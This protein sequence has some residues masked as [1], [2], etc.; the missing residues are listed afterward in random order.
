[1]KK[2]V[3]ITAI[4]VLF[5]A[6][7]FAQDIKTNHKQKRTVNG[8]VYT[9]E[10]KPLAGATV[11]V[12]GTSIGA[13]TNSKGAF[14]LSFNIDKNE[15]P[16]VISYVGYKT[17]D[18]KL[19]PKEDNLKIVL[20]ES[21]YYLEQIV[22]TG[23]RAEQPLKEAAII[24]RM[25]SEKEISQ[26]NPMDVTSIL[27]FELPGLQFGRQHGTGLPTMNF[28]GGDG[29][30]VLFL[31]DGEK[32]SGEGAG[33]NVDFS[34]FNVDRIER[35][36]VV[37]GAM[38]TLYG[39]S[40]LGGVINII[41]KDANRPFTADFDSRYAS[42]GEHKYSL[43]AGT[44]L[45][46]FSSLS[47]FS[48][49]KKDPF[50]AYD[51]SPAYH[52]T[53]KPDG[54][55]DTQ[56]YMPSVLEVTG[57][58]LWDFN[59]KLKYNISERLTAQANVSYYHNKRLA[60]H[61]SENN[62]DLYKDLAANIKLRYTLSEGHLLNLSYNFDDFRKNIVSLK[63]DNVNEIYSDLNNVVNLNYVGDL[64]ENN[65]LSAGFEFASE[66]L[67]H[68]MFADS[69]FRSTTNYVFF[70]Q[71]EGKYWDKVSL[72]PG[73]RF[74]YHSVY[75]LNVTPRLS[76]MYSLNDFVFRGGIA[77]GYRSPSLKELYSDYNM[78]GLNLFNIVGNPDLKPEKSLQYSASTE[79]SRSNMNASISANY[80]TYTDRIGL[81]WQDNAQNKKD[82]VY[83]N[84]NNSATVGLDFI[85][86]WRY[87]FGL[88]LNFSYSYIQETERV[89]GL[90]YF[91][92][93]PHSMNLGLRYG[94]D[95]G[96]V[97]SF[98]SFNSMWSSGIRAVVI[99]TT[100]GVSYADYEPRY[101]STLQFGAKLPYGLRANFGIDNIFDFRDSNVSNT[102]AILP[103]QGRSYVFSLSMNIADL[104]N[105]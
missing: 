81:R 73:V 26:I 74:D 31:V 44:K 56:V 49:R 10:G 23:T 86:R 14:K 70:I 2:I 1:M 94:F 50:L 75:N 87:D 92:M 89:N 3:L 16:L 105:L 65:V 61:K 101:R 39:S 40:A 67:K 68:Y 95:I 64:G 48:F 30:Y 59:Q 34:R 12:K 17:V 99:E 37:K 33:N 46:D 104:L 38:S 7:A 100:E 41:T 20:E 88:S 83:Y 28:Q 18:Y 55:I 29:S 93:R 19:K 97:E 76:A 79:F 21:P 77:A 71:N 9:A 5:S 80:N 15:V 84:T 27:Q 25:I 4:A 51:K 98:I 52:Y 35:V 103:E 54:R 66:K 57:Y 11:V 78:G 69:G 60:Y 85:L 24:T 47:S 62:E 72:V 91:A 13:G 8:L 63:S 96:S 90:N 42:N 22:V 32:V 36:E 58:E 6:F 43:S 53:Q 102:I 82:L 45:S